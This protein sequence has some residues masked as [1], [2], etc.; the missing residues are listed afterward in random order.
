MKNLLRKSLSVALLGASLALAVESQGQISTIG[1]G[2]DS[3][4]SSNPVSIG[5]WGFG[6]NPPNANAH[7][8]ILYTAD[9]INAGGV[10]GARM[11]DSIAWDV[12][13]IP[14]QALKGYSVKVKVTPLTELNDFETTGFTTAATLPTY[15]PADTTWSWIPFSTPIFWNGVDNII[16][17]ICTDTLK[18]D[19]SGMVRTYEPTDIKNYWVTISSPNPLCGIYTS[20]AGVYPTTDQPNIKMAFT[21]PAPSCTGTP[22]VSSLIPAIDTVSVCAGLIQTFQITNPA[23]SNVVYQWQESING[24][25][26]ADIASANATAYTATASTAYNFVKYRVKVTCTATGLFSY[27]GEKVL[28]TSAGAT[29]ATLPYSQNFESW[30]TRCSDSEIPDDHWSAI[31]V[32]GNG[33]WRREDQGATA[34]WT[35]DVTPLYYF[36]YSSEGSHSA[37]FRT[38]SGDSGSLMLSLDCSAAG[39]KELRFDY[40]NKSGALTN[41]LEILLSTDAGVTFNSIAVFGPQG[42][43]GA[44][45]LPQVLPFNSTSATTIIKFY[46]TG[47]YQSGD[48]DMGID[49]LLV[50][51]SCEGTPV[52]GEVDSTAGCLGES[53]HLTLSGDTQGGGVEY[54]WQYSTDGIGWVDLDTVASPTAPLTQA[55]WYRAI[56]ICTNSGLSDTTA[57]RLVTV[58]PFYYCYCASASTVSSTQLNVGNVTL[59]NGTNDTLINNGNPLP[60]TSN[61]EAKK[62][63]SNYTNLTPPELYMDSTYHVAVTYFTSNGTNVYP[64]MGKSNTKIWIDFDHN[65]QFDH[66]A[67][68]IYAGVKPD[69]SFHTDF[70]FVVPNTALSGITGMRIV[71][72]DDYDS[73]TVVPCGPYSFGETEDYLVKIN[74]QSCNGPVDAGVVT[75]SDTMSC[76]GY[77][78]E[79]TN[80]AYD[81]LNAPYSKVWQSSTNQNT[82]TDIAGSQDQDMISTTIASSTT[83]YRIKATCLNTQ[84]VSYSDTVKVALN[85]VCYCV[86]Y[87]DGGYSGMQDSSDVGSFKFGSINIPLVGGHLSNAT[88]TS[89]YANNHSLG[90]IELK[91][92]STYSFVLDHTILRGTDADAKITMFIDYN[93]NGVFD[94]PEERVY[95]SLSE[96]GTWHKTGTVTIPADV[97][98]NTPTG[99]R[100]II[101][102]DTEPNVASDEACG[103]YT[104]GETEDYSVIFNRTTGIG[105]VSDHT[106]QF[107]LYPNPTTGVVTLYY[108]GLAQKGASVKVQ[109]VIGQVL[110]QNDI[111][112]LESGKTIELDL[113]NY[114]KGVYLI[115]LEVGD[116]KTTKKVVVQ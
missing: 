57:P 115:Q 103:I 53:V 97:V 48:F 112:Y 32:T 8:Q 25:A 91:A 43:T 77:P 9:Q 74:A 41:K 24:G 7:M 31:P 52:A 98:V 55:T 5:G 69:D 2:T 113:K 39:Q 100:L 94:I 84:D 107:V 36:P 79:L 22:A 18:A 110:F 61:Q 19:P 38:S 109:N 86:S 16:F 111:D 14:A 70:D 89:K 82:W 33:S 27:S 81:L 30:M 26:W 90:L 37:R 58:N 6:W 10:T 62:H 102:N 3:W 92:D 54:L 59:V 88:A 64:Q 105:Q 104:S 80:S 44:Q 29:Y 45:W 47:V 21:S 116:S 23:Q 78:V 34:N 67:E 51:P 75:T 60:A 35:E 13:A 40:F 85:P 101:N 71:T 1:N 87:A 106:N 95:S 20:P 63:Y 56:V 73:T 11:L 66:P 96:T 17:D 42:V 4:Y 108:S 68:L 50:L 15:L 93:A 83:W 114:A 46:G 76:P 12:L 99:L 72:N 65:G 28:E 49:N